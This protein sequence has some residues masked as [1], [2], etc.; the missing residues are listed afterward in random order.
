MQIILSTRAGN[1]V[2]RH[3]ET[4]WRR[5]LGKTLIQNE[6]LEMLRGKKVCIL[7]HGFNVKEAFGVYSELTLQLGTT[8]DA[9]LWFTWPGSKLKLGFWTARGRAKESGRRLAKA[10][11]LLAED[12][13]THLDY[14]G[15]SLGCQVGLEALKAGLKVRNL[16]LA[17]PAVGDDSLAED[18]Y[19]VL[20]HASRIIIAHS[21]DDKVLARAYRFALWDTALGLRGP[22]IPNLVC[23]PAE[24]WK[25][26]G[27]NHSDYKNSPEYLEKWK[28]LAR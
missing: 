25:F 19:E 20:N 12:E 28:E 14:Q 8:Y 22:R 6:A 13:N 9:Y 5:V 3:G 26:S 16:I 7:G 23:P 27:L 10:L 4:S 15:H 17:A 1:S 18:Y 2:F 21:E 24:M 11:A